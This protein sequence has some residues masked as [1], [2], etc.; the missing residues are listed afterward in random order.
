M[1]NLQTWYPYQLD[2][3]LMQE[4]S[5]YL[6]GE[7]DF[8]SFRGSGCQSKTPIR[9]VELIEIDRSNSVIS[10]DIKANAFLQHM[11]RNIVGVLLKVGNRQHPPIWAKE[12]LVARDRTIA[13]ITAPP[14]G[15]CLVS[16]EYS[17]LN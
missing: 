9:N 7:N 11:V 13:G 16:V 17:N 8:T 10:I 2:H 14:Q 1:R 3:A 12:V 6:L 4:A 15:L 5:Q